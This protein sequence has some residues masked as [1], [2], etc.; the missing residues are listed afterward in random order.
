M[1]VLACA[2]AGAGCH[3]EEAAKSPSNAAAPAAGEATAWWKTEGE[4]GNQAAAAKL[5]GEALP[6]WKKYAP[7]NGSLASQGKELFTKDCA[8]CHT[9][10]RGATAG[11]DLQGVTHRD[12]PEW[13]SNF[14]SSPETMVKSD[15]QAKALMTKYLVQMPNFHLKGDEIEAIKAYLHQQDEAAK[16]GK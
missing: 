3:K 9:F 15:P 11:P 5:T 8:S 14:V 10:G 16:Q 13:I 1:F 12:T 7:V 4:G 2:L 6:G